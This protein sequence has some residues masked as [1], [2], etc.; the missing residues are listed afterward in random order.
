MATQVIPRC[1][2]CQQALFG[3]GGVYCREF[4]EDIY[5]ETVA[6]DCGAFEPAGEDYRPPASVPAPTARV[7]QLRPKTPVVVRDL[8][9]DQ[10]L[11]GTLIVTFFGRTAQ[12][13]QLADEVVATLR[14]H[15]PTSE[16]TWDYPKEETHA[17]PSV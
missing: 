10:C 11:E 12:G 13:Y 5:D 9:R 17:T 1:S 4:H 16:V 3:Q 6:A 8:E 2:D 7:V 15:Y 14:L